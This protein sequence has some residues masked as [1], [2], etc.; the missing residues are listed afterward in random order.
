MRLLLLLSFSVLLTATAWATVPST[1]SY[2]GVLMDNTGVLAPDGLYNFTFRIYDVGSGGAPLWTETTNNVAVAKGGFSVL[3]GNINPVALAFD[4]PYWLGIV[5]NGQPE[6]TPRVVLGA[7]PFALAL[8]LPFLGA[9]DSGGPLLSIANAGGGQDIVAGRWLEVG[10]ASGPGFLDVRDAAG[11]NALASLYCYNDIAATGARPASAAPAVIPPAL[12]GALTLLDAA[13]GDIV[14]AEPDL[15]GSGAGWFT[16]RGPSGS[17]FTVDA[18]YLGSPRLS[19]SGAASS[20]VMNT[21]VSGD[22]SVVLPA[23]AVSSA[24]ILDEAGIAQARLLGTSNVT[25]VAGMSDVVTVS[26]TTPADGYI[27]VTASGQTGCYGTTGANYMITQIDETA[28]GG[29]NS[30]YSVWAGANGFVNNLSEYRPYYN[31]RVFQK[32]AGSWTFRLEAM[33]SGSGTAY[34][35]NPT[36]TAMFVPTSYGG[37]TTVAT[38]AEAGAAGIAGRMAQIASQDGTR[39]ETGVVG[40][41]RDLELQV[42]R[43]KARLAES[44]LRLARAQAERQARAAQAAAARP[45]AIRK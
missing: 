41:L 35:W 45:A 13:A 33:K 43:E 12:G 8:R 16:V 32:S 19:V 9:D 15:D 39:A 11:P 4:R 22:L 1:I 18:N 25:N 34:F 36:L 28:G 10:S 14:R 38:V 17:S 37:V 42:A 29:E 31:Q 44:E 20:V 24:E 40:D 30:F 3:L 7:S 27:V 26:I 6:L 21:S 2:Q 5:V 23:G